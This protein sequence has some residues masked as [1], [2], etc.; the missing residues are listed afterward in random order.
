MNANWDR[1]TVLLKRKAMRDGM[2]I[3][4]IDWLAWREPFK[5]IEEEE[6]AAKREKKKNARADANDPELKRAL[7]ASLAES[8]AMVASGSGAGAGKG[9]RKL[10]EEDGKTSAEMKEGRSGSSKAEDPKEN[11][12]RAKNSKSKSAEASYILIE[13]DDDPSSS[14]AKLAP[15]SRPAP[16]KIVSLLTST[17]PPSSVSDALP[18][19]LPDSALAG[20][21]IIS[22]GFASRSVSAPMELDDSSQSA[23]DLLPPHSLDNHPTPRS[24]SSPPPTATTSTYTSKHFSPKASTSKKS[25]L[26][27]SHSTHIRAHPIGLEI[28]TLPT[29][30]TALFPMLSKTLAPT[31]IG[32]LIVPGEDSQTGTTSDEEEPASRRAVKRPKIENGTEA[33]K[34]GIRGAALSTGAS[35]NGMSSSTRASSS[36]EA[37]TNGVA[38]NRGMSISG[39]AAKSIPKATELSIKGIGSQEDDDD[40]VIVEPLVL[41]GLAATAVEKRDREDEVEEVLQ[42]GQGKHKRWSRR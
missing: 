26:N 24:Q 14:P 11:R 16:P 12:Q 40:I 17:N 42:D 35:G 2:T 8:A 1:D 39:I 25:L 33:T 34:L 4:S 9:K 30:P 21:P 3:E 27:P 20:P 10:I 22:R 31:S 29:I 41:T 6:L 23:I 19:A 5:K 7:Q 18:D 15:E 28:P 13:D 32:K 38:P 36:S 37:G